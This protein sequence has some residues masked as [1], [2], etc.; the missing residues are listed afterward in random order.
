MY[1]SITDVMSRSGSNLVGRTNLVGILPLAYTI[2]RNKA[3]GTLAIVGKAVVSLRK[4]AC[5]KAT[6]PQTGRVTLLLNG[7][8]SRLGQISIHDWF[9]YNSSA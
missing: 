3:V 5:I 7:K 4:R 9:M 6:K 8:M 1:R 2:Y